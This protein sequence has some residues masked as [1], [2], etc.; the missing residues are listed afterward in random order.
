M[1]GNNSVNLSPAV[2]TSV[3]IDTIRAPSDESPQT[4]TP[5]SQ[6]FFS[7]DDISTEGKEVTRQAMA[8]FYALLAI[9]NSER[10]DELSPR[11]LKVL[12]RTEELGVLD[13][14]TEDNTPE[15]KL[16]SFDKKEE[17][18]KAKKMRSNPS[19]IRNAIG[20]LGGLLK[21]GLKGFWY[22]WKKPNIQDTVC[23]AQRFLEIED[24]DMPEIVLNDPESYRFGGAGVY[25][26]TEHKL[27]IITDGK[28][29]LKVL[30]SMLS[31]RLCKLVDLLP[32]GFGKSLSSF[33]QDTNALENFL[34]HELT[35]SRQF[36]KVRRLTKDEAIE[37]IEVYLNNLD[38]T[39][40]K[41]LKE[42]IGKKEDPCKCLKE[43]F[44]N[45]FPKKR[46]GVISESELQ[47][48]KKTFVNL[49]D[50]FIYGIAIGKLKDPEAIRKYTSNSCEIE[51]RLNG[52]AFVANERIQEVTDGRCETV[53]DL[54][55]CLRL[56]RGV[57]LEER[58]IDNIILKIEYLKAQDP[59][60]PEIGLLER[61]LHEASELSSPTAAKAFL[62]QE[63][64][65]RRLKRK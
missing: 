19:I 47:E 60:N 38:D 64:V 61:E 1:T 22:G 55:A 6:G 40:I 39:R 32:E 35:H 63:R 8:I 9:K 15:I 59:L 24:N 48:S 7:V 50:A 16:P 30:V 18:K 51:A 41:L 42:R 62:F 65:A 3:P 57:L 49:L 52:G 17:E 11:T 46:E 54:N 28:I 36:S 23:K 37:V 4:E 34:A 13:P 43:G 56:I 27:H 26:P 10:R 58:K 2:R 20:F 53:G 29:L 45:L 31:K 14:S 5:Q 33:L 25:V 12:E 21:E 44:E